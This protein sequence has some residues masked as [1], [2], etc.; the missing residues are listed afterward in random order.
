M[1]K[2]L[3]LTIYPPNRLG[4]SI[5]IWYLLKQ[6]G[7]KLQRKRYSQEFK[8]QIVK[9]SLEV[10]NAAIVARKN[11]LS[12]N[13]V[14]RWVREHKN[15]NHIVIGQTYNADGLIVR[16]DNGPQFISHHFEESCIKFGIEHER[17]P[18]RTPNK[19]AHIE[20][21]NAIL[22]EECLSKYVFQSYS[23]AYDTVSQFIKNYNTVRIHSSLKYHTPNEA[24]RLLQQQCLEIQPVRV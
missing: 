2:K 1:F 8:D 4:Q 24:F 6:E 14:S 13:M 12:A 9:E 23:E 5:L 19:N 18:C 10:G 7:A 22:E 11:D 15:Q 17:I 20:S 16:S 21:F 3:G